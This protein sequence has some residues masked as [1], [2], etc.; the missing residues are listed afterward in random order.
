M[1]MKISSYSYKKEPF[2]ISYRYQRFSLGETKGCA[3]VST[4]AQKYLHTPC[5]TGYNYSKYLKYSK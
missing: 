5:A 3:T 1:N 4:L 2:R